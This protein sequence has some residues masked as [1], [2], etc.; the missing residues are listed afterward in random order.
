MNYLNDE[1]LYF[2]YNGVY[3]YSDEKV[4]KIDL[5]NLILKEIFPLKK[6]GIPSK[7]PEKSEQ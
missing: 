1:L 2:S 4:Y 7:K 5:S 6:K 3:F